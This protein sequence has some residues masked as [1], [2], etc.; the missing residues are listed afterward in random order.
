MNTTTS[1]NSTGVGVSIS[2]MLS[3]IQ[4]Y[5]YNPASIQRGALSA[6]SAIYRG[7]IDIV[8]GT[9]PFVFSLENSSVNV[10]AFMQQAAA[11]TRRQYAAAATTVEDLYLHMADKDF[12]N[13][14]AM[15]ST[16]KFTLVLNQ[17]E[18]LKSLV[19][20][21]VTKVYRITIPRNTVFYAASIPFSLQYP[22]NIEQLQHG[23]LQITYD[24]TVESPLQT[25]TTNIIDYE[26]INDTNGVS[27]VEFSVDTQQFEIVERVN[28]VSNTGGFKTTVPYSQQFYYARVYATNAN[29]VWSELKTTYTQEVF[30]PST[31]TAV[32]S[33]ANKAVT[34]TIPIVYVT[35]G[36]V[37]GKVR[38]DVYETMGP[39][40]LLLGNYSPADFSADFMSLDKADATAYTAALTSMASVAVYSRDVTSGGR[41]ALTFD[42]LQTRVIQ[43]AIGPRQLPIT[44][45]Q[46]QTTLLDY[47]YTLVKNVDTVTNRYYWAT[48]ALP[49]PSNPNLVTPANAAVLSLIT[50]LSAAAD[51]YG[52]TSYAGG[53]TITSSALI[54]KINGVSSL[55]S[56]NARNAINT[57]SPAQICTE[58]NSGHYFY[59]PF[60]YVLDTTVDT[61]EVRPYYLDK[62]AVLSASFVQTNPLTGFQ[63]A[64]SPGYTLVKT[65]QG[66]TLNITTKSNATYQ[67]LEDADVFCQL[68]FTSS[69]Q[70]KTAYLLGKQLPRVDDAGERTF[71]FTIDTNYDIDVDHQMSL[72]TFVTETANQVPRCDLTQSFTIIFGTTVSSV[73]SLASSAIDAKIGKFQLTP[74]AV[75]ITHQTL[76]IEFGYHLQTVWNSY[77]TIAAPAPYQTYAQDVPLL[78]EQDVYK[79]NPVTGA[80]FTIDENGKFI[81]DV[82]HKAGTQVVDDKGSKVFKHKAGDAILDEYTG[83]PKPVANYVSLMK[84]SIDVVVIDA[85]YQY[86]NDAITKEY[87]AEINNSLI[88]S[89]KDELVTINDEV[90]EQTQVYYYPAVTKGDVNV[91]ANNNQVFNMEAAQSLNVVMYVSQ[92]TYNNT[93]LL[94]TLSSITIQTI[95]NYLAANTTVALSHLDDAL[96]KAYGT[97]VTGVKVTG[98]GGGDYNVITVTDSSTLLSVNKVLAVQPNGQLMVKEDINIVFEIHN[99]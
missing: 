99:G 48:K 93:K 78:Y 41:N 24:T 67:A 52:C 70:N 91:I 44:P 63:V 17:N 45:A 8:D 81:Y 60:Y 9:N 69:A 7:E 94:S 38:V 21:P 46:I 85:I 28:E 97:D 62:P 5:A 31:P 13:I 72:T 33:V 96:I 50:D 59:T 88:A 55:V 37:S 27:Y 98:L 66:Y 19:Q 2:S 49:K 14:F 61:F 15:P 23:G 53:V 76:K 82:L 20:D 83:L 65:E 80:A 71:V 30:N 16:T 86:A 64:V 74:A 6:L 68:S 51:A 84:R 73:S 58:L 26:I 10:A 75:G 47:G 12:I 32:V 18:L 43:N 89:L 29:G 34:V 22:V 4:S 40:N 3:D 95:G 11:L 36:Q 54:N 90:L 77:R 57:L 79:V 87:V 1:S 92:D 25:L 56:K 42:Q 39:M 35:T